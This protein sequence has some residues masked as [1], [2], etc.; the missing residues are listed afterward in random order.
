MKKLLYVALVMVLMCLT[1]PS[2][3]INLTL[4]AET[5]IVIDRDVTL[6][7]TNTNGE[8]DL[9]WYLLTLD[10]QAAEWLTI[11]PKVGVMHQS[12]ETDQYSAII[13]NIE[14]DSE[15]GFAVGVSAQADVYTLEG[16]HKYADG[17]TFSLIGEY[18]YGQTELDS[19]DLGGI[20]IE[21]PIRNDIKL[22]QFELGG[23]VSKQIGVIKPYLGVVYSNLIGEYDFNLSAVNMV[24]DIEADDNVGL[25]LGFTANPNDNVAISV[26]G[27]LIDSY[28]IGGSCKIRF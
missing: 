8:M 18:L 27:K 2:Y 13:G 4:G 17:T 22:H 1:V 3:A 23:Q 10:I 24:E 28:G 26:D 25:R 9:E 14:A 7:N 21:N 19:V 15:V 11:T 20:E 16:V 12:F 5:Q 6:D